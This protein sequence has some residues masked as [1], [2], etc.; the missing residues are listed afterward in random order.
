MNAK[1]RG[2]K[3]ERIA[4]GELAKFDIDVA[5]PM[6]D[7]LPFDFI[8]YYQNTLIKVQVKSGTHSPGE[9]TGS[10]AFDL[11]TN[12]YRDAKSKKKY[13]QLDCDVMML[14]DY[15]NV[16]L[17][18]PSDFVDRRSFTIRHE[19][20]KNGQTKGINFHD[21]YVLSKKRI[22]EVLGR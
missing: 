11:T 7:N 15:N 21:D 2:E 13:S 3:G 22:E 5:I 4:I 6:T 17:I 9:C 8:I 18:G 16:Y 10:V 20:P 1:S 19:I 14:C 12:R